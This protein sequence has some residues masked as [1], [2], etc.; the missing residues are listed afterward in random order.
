MIS[1][2]FQS[3]D[4]DG[5]TRKRANTVSEGTKI[6]ENSQ[7][8][9]GP[10]ILPTVFKWDGGGKNVYISGSFSDWKTIPMVRR[11]FRGCF[12]VALEII[13]GFLHCRKQERNAGLIIFL[14]SACS[15]GDFVAIVDLPEGEHSY[16]YYIDGEWKCD[17]GVVIRIASIQE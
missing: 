5:G 13:V 14:V 7:A 17:P 12:V 9:H 3:Q 16:R 11:Y 10:K 6:P 1:L 8:N 15:H 4:Y 2:I